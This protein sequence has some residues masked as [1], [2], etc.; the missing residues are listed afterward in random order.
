MNRSL[1]VAAN[2]RQKAEDL[3]INRGLKSDLKLSDTEILKIAHE[4][5]VFQ[6]ELEMLNQEFV[7]TEDAAKGAVEKYTDLYDFAPSGYFT[8]SREGAIVELNL[9]A[10]LM[11]GEDRS[12]LKNATFGFFVSD[13]NK[14]IF[15]QFLQKIFDTHS[16]EN[17]EVTLC[18]NGNSTMHVYLTGNKAAKGDHCLLTMVDITERKMAEI[19]LNEKMDELKRFHSLIIGRE[20]RMIELKK[21]VNELLRETGQEDKYL[22]G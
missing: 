10:S 8:L 18:S 19:V 22:I 13:D 1:S 5:E 2:L 9:L 11:L 20:L 21:E 3:L 15:S 4:L 12:R 17:C 6:I 14:A 7:Q 16:R